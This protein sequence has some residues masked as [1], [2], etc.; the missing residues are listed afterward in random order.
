MDTIKII[1]SGIIAVLITAGIA[2]LISDMDFGV[3]TVFI[4][5]GIFF[6]AFML[7]FVII[8]KLF[9]GANKTTKT[10]IGKVN[11]YNET[12]DLKRITRLEFE[13]YNKAKASFQYFSSDR[14]L[15]L[16]EQYQAKE[17]DFSIEQLALEEEMVKR[18][19]IDFSPMHEKLYYMN[20]KS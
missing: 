15:N 11:E 7:S 18:K 14:L 1:L 19:L 13:K 2:G 20:H 9:E 6:G 3:F 16:Y 12:T 10:I 8:E 4:A 5:V 17:I